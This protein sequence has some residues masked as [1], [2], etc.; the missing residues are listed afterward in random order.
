MNFTGRPQF[1]SPSPSCSGDDLDGLLSDFFRA[2]MPNPWPGSPKLPVQTLLPRLTTRRW[3]LGRSRFALAAS[4]GLIVAGLWALG[5]KFTGPDPIAGFGAGN[6]EG[7]TRL[8]WYDPP[9]PVDPNKVPSTMSLFQDPE[10]G[11]KVRVDV[12]DR[13]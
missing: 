12:F 1:D 13:K 8:K 9:R 3:T 11:T 5:G 6:P 2:E 4:V 7:A 10:D